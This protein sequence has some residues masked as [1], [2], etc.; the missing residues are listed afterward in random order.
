MRPSR[1]QKHPDASGRTPAVARGP[2]ALGQ[3]AKF[4]FGA[5]PQLLIPPHEPNWSSAL[6]GLRRSKMPPGR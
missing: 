6:Q 1:A 4:Q 2:A 5:N 3:S